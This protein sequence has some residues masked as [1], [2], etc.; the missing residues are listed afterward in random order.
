MDLGRVELAGHDVSGLFQA[1][2]RRFAFDPGT[3]DALLATRLPR[4][5]RERGWRFS[6]FVDL[7]E[8]LIADKGLTIGFRHNMADVRVHGF[9]HGALSPMLLSSFVTADEAE[10]APLPDRVVCNGEFFRDLLVAEGLPADRATVGAALRYPHLA[11]VGRVDADRGSNVLVTMPLAADAAAELLAKL[12]EAF[13]GSSPRVALKPHPMSDW[14][15]IARGGV[16]DHFDLVSGGMDEHL[17]RAAVVVSL[18][19]STLYEALA[20]G[21]P[22][23]VVGRESALDLNPL[24]W[25]DDAVRAVVSPP[26][27]RAAVERALN[28]SDDEL[29]AYRERSRDVLKRSFAPIDDAGLAEFAH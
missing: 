15:G 12:S 13:P 4:R 20:A 29:R 22:A 8:N 26:D 16:P 7:Y 1:D 3:L 24:D 19:S 11:R 21:V 14:A 2:L 18:A 10:H 23:V 5:L 28:M 25:G 17:G 27:I 9:Q 6:V